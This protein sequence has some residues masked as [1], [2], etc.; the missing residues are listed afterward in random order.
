MRSARHRLDELKAM[1][2]E[3]EGTAKLVMDGGLRNATFWTNTSDDDSIVEGL[4]KAGSADCACGNCTVE[5]IIRAY[6][7]A[8]QRA[9]K[10]VARLTH[11]IENPDKL[12]KKWC[13][14]EA[15]EESTQQL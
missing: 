4:T 3:L 7:D 1:T 9:E 8:V 2:G 5:H 6:E 15:T 10:Y 13:K 12:Q 11:N 14:P